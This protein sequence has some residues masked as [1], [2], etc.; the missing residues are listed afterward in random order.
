[1]RNCQKCNNN[2]WSFKQNGSTIEATCNVCGYEVVFPV[3]KKEP[4]IDTC[5]KCGG[6]LFLKECKFNPKKLKKYYYYSHYLKC[7]KCN[8][9][10][11]LEKH[12]IFNKE[13]IAPLPEEITRVQDNLF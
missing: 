4:I 1:M 5:R 7:T 11:F 12:K 3:K 9:C 2:S 10:Y 13:Y 6:I 8:Q